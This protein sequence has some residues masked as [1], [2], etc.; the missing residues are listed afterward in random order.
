MDKPFDA[1]PK[2]LFP[3][4]NIESGKYVLNH[5]KNLKPGSSVESKLFD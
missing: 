2:R 3:F 4:A 5:G 1:S